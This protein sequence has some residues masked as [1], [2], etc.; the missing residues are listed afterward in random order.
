MK[1]ISVAEFGGP[2]VMKVVDI[3]MPAAREGEVL[4][5]RAFWSA[6]PCCMMRVSQCWKAA[7]NSA[8]KLVA[9]FTS[10]DSV[11][12]LERLNLGF[13]SCSWSTCLRTWQCKQDPAQ[14]GGR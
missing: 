9:W 14:S 8:R 13:A 4:L 1:G 10:V 12:A 11:V 7:S 6:S 2:D 3:A 5:L